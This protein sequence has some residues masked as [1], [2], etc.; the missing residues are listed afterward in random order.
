MATSGTTAFNPEQSDI[1]EDAASMA[2]VELRTGYDMR[3]ARFALNLLL[4]EWGNR[5]LNLWT[6]TEATIPLVAST[7]TYNLPADTIDV[8][9]AAIRTDSGVVTAQTDIAIRRVGV[10][11]YAAIPNK[12]ST[13]RPHQY[14]VSRQIAPTITVWPVP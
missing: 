14:Y 11:T 12:L 4:Q 5:G 3:M 6:V 1:I 8:I 13:G 10:A 7:A 9:E 2:G